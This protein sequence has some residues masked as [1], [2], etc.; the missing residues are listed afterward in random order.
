M[1]RVMAMTDVAPGPLVDVWFH[2]TYGRKIVCF[3]VEFI[4]YCLKNINHKPL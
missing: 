3:W 2:S 1:I 4:F